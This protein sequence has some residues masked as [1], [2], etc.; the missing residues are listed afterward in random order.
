RL[1]T[2]AGLLLGLAA[3]GAYFPVLIFPAW[4]SFYWRR[5]VG[6]FLFAFLSAARLSLGVVALGF[7]YTGQVNASIHAALDLPDW[8]PWKVLS[9]EGFWTGV[10]WAYRIPVFIAYLAFLAM[11]TFWPAR[12]NLA[13]LLALSAALLIG[14][15]FWFADHGGMY[16]FWYLPLFL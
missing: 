4:L 3:G 10:H 13:Q 5:G 7:W 12:K 9:S 2:V 14:I 6:R 1:P 11:S 8:Q 15:Q 16:V